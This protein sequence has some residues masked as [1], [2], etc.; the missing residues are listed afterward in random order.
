MP[1]AVSIC[2]EA[3]ADIA[4]D[5]IASMDEESVAATECRRSFDNVVSDLLERSDWGF[6]VR[7]IS[8]S[9]LT[10]DRVSEWNY[11]YSKPAL[12]SR[13][14]RVL[15]ASDDSCPEWGVY[16]TPIWD[17]YGT[18]PFYEVGG[19]IYTNVEDAVIE[20]SVATVDVSVFPSLFRRAVAVELAARIAY[21]IKKDRQLRGDMIQLSE[22]A[23]ARAIADDQNR[24]PRRQDFVSQAEL[25]RNGIAC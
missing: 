16:S 25:A 1:S 10:N 22:I 7:R 6:K 13:V 17:M 3:L 15:P 2:N 23:T 24:N 18:I 8:G 4:A 11:A 14:L 21:P 20:Y 9:A 12:A 19:T 5:P